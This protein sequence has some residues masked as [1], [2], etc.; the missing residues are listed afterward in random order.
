M[1]AGRAD[2]FFDSIPQLAQKAWDFAT[3]QAQAF[4]DNL[5]NIL[6]NPGEFLSGLL[7]GF[8]NFFATV[9]GLASTFASDL[10]STIGSAIR[11]IIGFVNDASDVDR[12][13][14]SACF[15]CVGEADMAA[16]CWTLFADSRGTVVQETPLVG[17]SKVIG[18]GRGSRGMALGIQMGIAFKVVAERRTG[19]FKHGQQVN[20]AQAGLPKHLHEVSM[21]LLLDLDMA[22]M[23]K[24]PRRDDQN[25]GIV[26]AGYF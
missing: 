18:E 6:N 4:I 11:S 10:V 22:A 12:A 23:P 5:R 2:Q 15:P 26:R 13:G 20:D 25:D 16:V 17:S 7:T 1:R 19:S 14:Q 9:G 24:D 21:H 3:Q 8:E